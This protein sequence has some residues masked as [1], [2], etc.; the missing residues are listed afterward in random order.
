MRF[1]GFMIALAAG[2]AAVTPGHAQDANAQQQAQAAVVQRHIDAYRAR[3]MEAFLRTFASDAVL[4]YG[5]MEFRGR[6]EIRQAY[7]L[8]FAPGAPGFEILA[9]GANDGIVW[10]ETAY[11]F[12]SGDEICC[13]YSEYTVEG[14]KITLLVVSGP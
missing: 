14:G 7:S 12:P 3:D 1:I 11:R 5:G 8:N 2:C 10:M 4:V 13:G 9:S 6:A